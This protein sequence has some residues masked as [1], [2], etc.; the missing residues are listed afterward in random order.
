M[1]YAENEELVGKDGE[2]SSEGRSCQAHIHKM[3]KQQYY[4]KQ[5]QEIPYHIFPT[6]VSCGLRL[7]TC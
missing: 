2:A 6:I 4:V 7:S 1:P 3:D 5:T